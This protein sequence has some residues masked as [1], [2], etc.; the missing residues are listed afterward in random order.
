MRNGCISVAITKDMLHLCWT[1][2]GSE[3]NIVVSIQRAVKIR[4]ID[5]S[6]SDFDNSKVN[7]QIVNKEG[8]T[9]CA[10]GYLFRLWKN[11]FISI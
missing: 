6:S 9:K 4:L 10:A 2:K 8:E 3:R 11:I 7:V 5:H 1:K